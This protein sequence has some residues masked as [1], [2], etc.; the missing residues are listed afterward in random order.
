MRIAI[1]YTAAVQ[2]G[3]GIGR[4]TRGLVAALARGDD[5]NRYTLFCAGSGPPPTQWPERFAV[6]T[7]GIR[8]SWLAIGWHRLHLPLYADRL[9][10]GCDIFHSPDFAL[11]P[12]RRAL[13]VVTVHDLSFLRVPECADPKL[14]SYLETVVPR[15][16]KAARRVLADSK[17]TRNDLTDYLRV[18]P[19]KISVIPAG[20]ASHFLPITDANVLATVQAR[21]SLPEQ[22][23]LTVGTLEPR[24]NFA[25]LISAYGRLRRQSGL[26]HELVIVGRPGWL[27]DDIFKRVNEEKLQGHVQFTGFVDDP[28]LPAVYSLASLFAF[29]SLYEGF[30]M[31]PLE[32]M[33]CGVPVVCSNNSSLPEAVGSAALMVDAGDVE[34]LADAM[35]RIL[36]D[37]ALQA[38]LRTL[39]QEQAA[40]YSWDSAA[41]GLLDAYQQVMC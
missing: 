28:D 13:G 24:K 4:Y 5:D 20:V 31:P 3:A 1:D 9:I 10:G 29:P 19:E 18:P 33:A 12:L 25:R 16:V 39:G 21:Y 22:F 14:R 8:A 36:E 17:S 2:Q 41:E 35:A 27:Y 38:Q 40:R 15:S 26:R 30:G 7:T 32:A 6:H 34:A 37:T 23:I 11:P